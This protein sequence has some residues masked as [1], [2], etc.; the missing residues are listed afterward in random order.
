VRTPGADTAAILA[1]ARRH[2]PEAAVASDVGSEL[3]FRLPLEAAPRLPPLL[4]AFDEGAS[5]GIDSYGACAAAVCDG[6]LCVLLLLHS[7]RSPL[8]HQ[9]GERLPDHCA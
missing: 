4:S 5:F 8:D 7:P 3:S 6:Y 9:H 2:V 1:I